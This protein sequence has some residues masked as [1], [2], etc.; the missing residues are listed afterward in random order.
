[1]RLSQEDE[2][3]ARYWETGVDKMVGEYMGAWLVAAYAAISTAEPQRQKESTLYWIA[4]LIG[5]MLALAPVFFPGGALAE[6]TAL[7]L[8]APDMFIHWFIPRAREMD[9]AMGRATK[10]ATILGV[11]ANLL[12]TM[13]AMPA[14]VPSAKQYLQV[15]VAKRK[16]DLEALYKAD[17]PV[18]VR[19][20]MIP[21]Y[22]ILKRGRRLPS[23][24]DWTKTGQEGHEQRRK[25]VW[26]HFMFPNSDIPYEA[27]NVGLLIFMQKAMREGLE[28]FNGQWSEWYTN[29]V[30]N[31]FAPK[32]L[33]G[34]F[35]PAGDIE[36]C[37][38]AKPFEPNLTFSGVPG[39]YKVR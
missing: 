25:F 18:W 33:L 26:N 39:V 9:Q 30:K 19:E 1:M 14:D 2:R 27:L 32:G 37:E 16:E 7:E 15:V 29:C 38:K 11:G 8:I 10:A 5:N 3:I 22:H 35:K 12:S 24:V 28:Q 31:T 23:Y 34:S 20:C 36:A 21:Y 17:V 13:K 4:S 6:A